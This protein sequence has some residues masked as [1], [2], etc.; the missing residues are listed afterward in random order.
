[1]FWGEP[2]DGVRQRIDRLKTLSNTLDRDLPPPEFGRRITALVRDTTQQAW[3]DAEAKVAKM[4]KG[5]AG[6]LQDHRHQSD[7]NPRSRRRASGA[8]RAQ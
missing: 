3:A 6:S 1:M 4:A 5:A 2:L 8:Q 7:P